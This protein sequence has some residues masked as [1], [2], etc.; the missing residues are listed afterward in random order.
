MMMGIEGRPESADGKSMQP[1]ENYGVQVMSIGFLVDAD[2][3]M[4]WRG[5]MATQALEQLLEGGTPEGFPA[6][7]H[8]LDPRRR[9]G[10]FV[11]SHPKTMPK[12][13]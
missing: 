8:G 5:P 12:T 11:Q 2:N 1:L 10:E 6:G 13:L 4:I 9:V 7:D 3:P